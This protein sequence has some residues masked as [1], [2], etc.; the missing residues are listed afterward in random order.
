LYAKSP[1]FHT[2]LYRFL[3]GRQPHWYVGSANASSSIADINH[4]MT[5]RLDGAHQELSTDVSK[6]IDGAIPIND[7]LPARP[8]IDS[9]PAFF[10]AGRLRA[11]QF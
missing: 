2:K 4:E 9:L 1:L 5:L 7:K 8:E 10:R 3:I 6:I 11:V